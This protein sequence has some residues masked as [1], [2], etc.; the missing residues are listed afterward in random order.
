[1]STR[2]QQLLLVTTLGV[3]LGGVSGCAVNPAT[4]GTSVVLSGSNSEWETGQEMYNKF[5]EEGAFYEDPELQAYVEKIGQRL[6]AESDMPDRKFTFS[7]IDAPE[8]NAFATPGGFIYVNR[9]LIGYLNTEAELA[10]VIGHEIAHVTARHHG[11]RKTASTTS[12]V[13]STTA[14]VLTG[15][16][17]VYEASNMYGAEVISGYGRDME[18]E[19]DGLGAEYMYKAGY[20]PEALLDVI[21]VLKNQEQFMRLKAKA[22]GKSGTTYHGLY[23]TH[24]R[25]DKRLQT[26]IRAANE[27]DDGTYIESPEEPGEFRRVTDGLVWGESVEGQR[28]DDRYYHNKLGFT[29]EQPEGWSVTTSSQSVVA[30]APDG[31]A[32]LT[33]TLRRKDPAATPQSV[34]ESS[35]NGEL[36]AGETLQQSGLDGYT[37]V[38][39]AA[40]KNKRLAVFNLGNLT[41]LFDGSATDFAASDAQLRTLIESFRAMHPKEKSSSNGRYV[42]YIQVPRGADVGSLA[43]STRIPDAEAQ[44]R[45]I[46]DFYPRGEPRTGDWIKVIQ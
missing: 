1:M 4:G 35:A 23:A 40:G 33:I 8:I 6:V 16:S 46:N 11:R 26:V 14:Y 19:A 25:N 43:A 12:K 31:S 29:I 32:S 13:L 27:L 37:A 18:L 24:P 17:A 21:G 2:F 45:L 44:L 39:A 28:A 9:G 7:I 42:R 10:G 3:A 38:A 36:S 20:E 34:L 30:A 22:A 5:L 41:Y 15:S